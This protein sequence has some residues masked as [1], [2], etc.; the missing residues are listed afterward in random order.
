MKPPSTAP[1]LF[2]DPPTI[3]ITRIRKVKRS[4]W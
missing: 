3:T 2:P 4:G 1:M